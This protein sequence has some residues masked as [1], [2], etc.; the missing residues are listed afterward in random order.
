MTK[1]FTYWFRSCLS[2]VASSCGWLDVRISCISQDRALICQVLYLSHKM[3]T[4]QT[5]GRRL[6]ISLIFGEKHKDEQRCTS[7]SHRAA[8][9]PDPTPQ[10][11]IN[12]TGK[13]NTFC[14]S[15]S[16]KIPTLPDFITKN[17]CPYDSIWIREIKSLVSKINV[18]KS[19]NGGRKCA[20]FP[21]VFTEENTS[22]FIP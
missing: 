7:E 1:T 6:E 15:W 9:G 2:A 11:S 10:G 22:L 19:W 12:S 18:S 8:H 3:A 5:A 21:D 17:L 16:I 20:W 13:Q 4:I 14:I